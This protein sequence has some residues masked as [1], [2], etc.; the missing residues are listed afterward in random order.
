ML[1]WFKINI[2]GRN[3]GWDVMR[4]IAI[5]LV[6]GAHAFHIIANHVPKTVSTIFLPDGVDIFFVLSGFL[7]GRIWFTM[8]QQSQKIEWNLFL[9]FYKR[10][11]FRTVP[12]YLVVISALFLYR[13]IASDFNFQWPWQYYTFT[14]NFF[15]SEWDPYFFYPEGWSLAV[16]EWFYLTM[17]II[18][19]LIL[20]VFK[21]KMNASLLVI[22][23]YI[24]LPLVFRLYVFQ[25]N[26]IV[27]LI[28]WNRDIR[29]LVI[30]RLDSIGWGLLIAWIFIFNSSLWDELRKWTWLSFTLFILVILLAQPSFMQVAYLSTFYFSLFAF[31][32]ALLMPY[33]ALIKSP[34]IHFLRFITYTSLFSYSTYLLNRTFVYKVVFM[35][36]KAHFDS[37]FLA[38]VIFYIIFFSIVFI[39]AAVFYFLVER[40]LTKL[41][42]RI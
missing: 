5:L 10:R 26:E 27:D 25:H 20:H 22:S 38:A 18:S 29:R 28:A 8:I 32:L 35:P 34:N 40:P 42:D 4:A 30:Y 7:V 17:P 31:A 9:S 19:V 12:V 15:Q 37:S 3:F 23:F 24:V 2:S 11:W 36:Y 14:Q 41:R 1:S 33:I 6:L 39:V 21:N 13:W 16:E